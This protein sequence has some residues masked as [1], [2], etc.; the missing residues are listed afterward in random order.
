MDLDKIRWKSEVSH[1]NF[2]AQYRFVKAKRLCE[3]W[4]DK[5]KLL[6]LFARMRYE[7]YKVK[8][9]T[10]I[11]ARCKIGGDSKSDISEVLYLIRVLKLEKMLIA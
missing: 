4:A 2:I 3:Y 9:N 11:P 7:H 5:N 8:Y 1:P 6:Y 10:D